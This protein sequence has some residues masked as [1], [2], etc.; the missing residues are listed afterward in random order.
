M[1]DQIDANGLTPKQRY[2]KRWSML[3]AER[4][5]W[6]PDYRD[7]VDYVAPLSGRFFYTDANKGNKVQRQKKVYDTT[8]KR[9]LTVLSAG[10]MAGMTSPARPWFRLA[11]SDRVLM[12]R[13]D[14]KTWLQDTTDQMREATFELHPAVLAGAGLARALTQ[15]AAANSAR[16]GIDIGTDIAPTEPDPVDPMVFAV[17]RELLSNVVRHSRATRATV[18]LETVD[19]MRRLDVVDDGTGLSA[20][21]AAERL[22]QGHIGLASQRAR[23]EA[24]G[25]TMRILPVPTGAHIRVTVPLRGSVPPR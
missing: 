6:L 16:S 8:A 5:T 1:P 21:A 25:G 3:R 20:D 23:I 15:L 10:L 19:G 2:M 12:E 24:A 7:L 17:A 14:V 4:A 13:H 11:L 22:R 18:R 9:S